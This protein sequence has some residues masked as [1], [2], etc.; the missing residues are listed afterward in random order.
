MNLTK[1]RRIT[2]PK[3]AKR[4]VSPDAIAY[5]SL[6]AAARAAGMSRPSFTKF[7]LPNIPHRRVGGRV[8]ISKAALER[9]LEGRDAEEAA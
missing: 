2:K 5:P 1:E 9:W 3:G 8:L 7:A 6:T 4:R